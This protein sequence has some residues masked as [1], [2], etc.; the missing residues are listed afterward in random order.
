LVRV[1]NGGTTLAAYGYDGT[2]RRATETH[3]TTTTDLYYSSSWQVLEERVG[4]VVQAR[5][6]W[7]PVYVNALVLRDQSSQHNGVLD[8]RLYVQTDANWNVTALVDV[9]G[10]VAERYVYDPYGAVTVLTPA[11][12]ARGTSAYGWIYLFQGERFDPTVGLFNVNGRVYSPTL[13][14]PEQADP[15]GLAP[16]INDY[17]WERNNSVGR[18]DPSGLWDDPNDIAIGMIGPLTR[19]ASII[20]AAK[21]QG[22]LKPFLKEQLDELTSL[23]RKLGLKGCASLTLLS[24]S[25]SQVKNLKDNTLVGLICILAGDATGLIPVNGIRLGSIQL[26]INGALS[27]IQNDLKGLSVKSS[28]CDAGCPCSADNCHEQELSFD[29]IPMD[30]PINGTRYTFDLDLTIKVEFCTGTCKK[31][32][33]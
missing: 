14:R 7:S 32:K 21:L 8:Q 27:L 15:L 20:L 12:T 3:G 5:N 10:N 1:N 28:N 23:S 22:A 33:N 13:G 30:I 24:V 26:L 2:G 16:D 17:R 19:A 31:K 25:R 18:I 29:D 9:N 4:G 11:W 6:V